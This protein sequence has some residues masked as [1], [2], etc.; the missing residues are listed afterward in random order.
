MMESGKFLFILIQETRTKNPNKI[1]IST[2]YNSIHQSNTNGKRGLAI[3][4]KKRFVQIKKIIHSEKNILTA[5]FKIFNTEI[6]ISNIHAP[7]RNCKG[8]ED[9]LSKLISYFNKFKLLNVG[10]IFAGDFNCSSNLVNRSRNFIKLKNLF[11]RIK[12]EK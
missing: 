10:I 8:H 4:F 3:Y 7:N 5:V 9:F 2:K 11:E 12:Y 6:I 1:N